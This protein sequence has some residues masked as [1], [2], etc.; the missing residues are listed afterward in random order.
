MEL[1]P[2]IQSTAVSLEAGSDKATVL[3]Y[4]ELDGR[5]YFDVACLADAE[6]GLRPEVRENLCRSTISF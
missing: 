4:Q 3:Q 5:R 2:F 6:R 1:H